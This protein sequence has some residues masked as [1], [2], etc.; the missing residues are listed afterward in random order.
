MGAIHKPV[1]PLSKRFG[2]LVV[3]ISAEGIR[4]R[5]YRRR[6]SRLV[7]WS[8]VCRLA[9]DGP[10]PFDRA[11]EPERAEQIRQWIEQGK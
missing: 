2:D 7:T 1:R 5:G 8:A 3:T 6:R 9:F 11:I 10:G 4:L